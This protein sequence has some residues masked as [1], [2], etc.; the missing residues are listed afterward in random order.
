[1]LVV[2]ALLGVEAGD[3]LGLAVGVT[4][5]GVPVVGLAVVSLPVVGAL[6]GLAVGT[7]LGLAVGV[8]L[9]G[10]AGDS[11][12]LEVVGDLLGDDGPNE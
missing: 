3:S 10:A 12:G 11:L 2:G 8:A 5:V 7:L 6:L 9:G 1:M 4:V